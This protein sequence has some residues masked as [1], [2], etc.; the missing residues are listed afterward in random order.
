MSDLFSGRAAIVNLAAKEVQEEYLEDDFFEEHLGGAS[1]NLA[2]Y[3]KYADD[4]PVVLGIGP[5]TGT[6]APAG[7]LGILT[8]KSPITGKVSHLNSPDSI[9]LYCVEKLNHP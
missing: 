6:L 1:A 7:S 8:G 5:L 3:E 9:F 2:L 4:D